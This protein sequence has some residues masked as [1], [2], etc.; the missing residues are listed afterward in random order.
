TPQ[1]TST[2]A[3]V[4]N[5]PPSNKPIVLPSSKK[6]SIP[7]STITKKDAVKK[8]AFEIH[9]KKQ[10]LLE[11]QIQQ[12]KLLLKKL[13]TAETNAEKESIRALMKQVDT[14]VVTLKDS[15]RLTSS[16]KSSST[17][18]PTKPTITPPPPTA[19]T[20]KIS[21]QDVLKQREKTLQKQLETLRAKT[22][23]DMRR[24]MSNTL[25]QSS[26]NF[27]NV[28]NESDPTIKSSA[29]D[30]LKFIE[31]R[32]QQI[33]I[34]NIKDLPRNELEE[35]LKKSGAIKIQS[36]DADNS[37]LVIYSSTADVDKVRK[38]GLT[39]KDRNLDIDF[40]ED[41]SLNISGKKRTLSETM[42]DEL[43]GATSNEITNNNDDDDE[44]ETK[45]K[46]QN[47]TSDVEEN[48][49]VDEYGDEEERLLADCEKSTDDNATKR[50]NLSFDNNDESNQQYEF[51]PNDLVDEIQ[52]LDS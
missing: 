17:T 35:F 44:P 36:N 23:A 42:E 48:E 22:S 11:E 43:L 26:L 49:E 31:Q 19:A 4:P 1:P 3:T 28:L 27:T 32:Q 38:N 51:E 47:Q 13:E 45:R 2:P 40:N 30:A 6:T 14:T 37:L 18:V 15:L 39:F 10:G 34:K 33:L 46:N 50:T 16:I 52:L 7:S 21:Q 29:N 25:G 8:A 20:T 5:P 24:A 41:S 9:C 12:Q